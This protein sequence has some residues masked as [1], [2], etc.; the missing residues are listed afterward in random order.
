MHHLSSQLKSHLAQELTTLTLCWKLTRRDGLTFAFTSCDTDLIIDQQIYQSSSSFTPSAIL[1]S[2]NL[3]VDNMEIE[4]LIAGDAIT[5][6]DILAG[7]YDQA[8]V[9]VFLA[10]YL[11]PEDGKLILR[12][13]W[14]GEVQAS[15]NHFVA[16]VRGLMQAFSKTIGELYSPSCR[17]TFCD[18]RCGLPAERYT[19]PGKVLRASGMTSFIAEE[20][21]QPDGYFSGGKVL[22]DT[23][24]NRRLIM[25]VR[26]QHG[27]KFDLM[28]PA[29]HGFTPGD[30]FN[31]TAGCDK[32]FAT[33]CTKFKNA[34]NFRGE[35][36]VPLPEKFN[37]Y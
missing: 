29:P 25:E 23:G 2:S 1:S 31:A 33:C 36:H 7:L 32:H 26:T 21:T 12:K 9:V 14:L 11:A 3:S 35:P 28:L 4:G 37:I 24:E 20:I 8:E 16:E 19:H 22:F 6:S 10:N 15:A 13:G 34:I 17:A 18:L 27:V 5:E 30:T